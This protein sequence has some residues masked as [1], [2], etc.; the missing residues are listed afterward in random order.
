MPAAQEHP[1]HGG[2]LAGVRVL[3][4]RGIGPVPF[5]AMLLAD[6][7]A[8][9]LQLA[10]P[11]TPADDGPT[12]RG[13]SCITLDLKQPA[14]RDTLLALLPNVDLLIEGFR[15]G[16]MERLGLGPAEC[17]ARQPRLVY[18]RMTGW[19]QEGPLAPLPCHDPNVLAIT[20]VLHSLG[21]PATPPRPPLNLVADLGGGALYLV[22]GVL[23]ALLHAR[24]SG[25]GQVVD[26]AMVDGVASL[27]SGVHELRAQ[28]QWHDQ[29]GVNFLDGS[30]PFGSSYACADG[31]YMLV[32]AVEPPFYARLLEG[33]GLAGED[34]PAQYDRRGWPRLHQRFTQ[35]FAT[36]PRDDWAARLEP[37][38][39]CASPVLDLA[40]APGHPQLAARRVY[41]AAGQPAA[42]PRFSATPIAHAPARLDSPAELLARWAAAT[43]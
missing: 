25:V 13:R 17:L 2:P 3:E 4:L 33:L 16:A 20:G 7:G 24:S 41:D 23:A 21:D 27:M 31:R 5:A 43:R 32:C 10:P 6:L 8:E 18:G 37:L 26:A 34:L 12:G 30:C 39:A 42:A 22:M 19:G 15:P 14:Q 38:G 11:G 1:S 9:I 29:R 35:V 40:E 36:R 28:G